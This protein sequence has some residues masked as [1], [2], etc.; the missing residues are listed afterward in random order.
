MAIA[1]LKSLSFYQRCAGGEFVQR[2]LSKHSMD[3][4]ARILLFISESSKGKTHRWATEVV[5]AGISRK[6]DYPPPNS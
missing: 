1:A 3:G 6:G 2:L 5:W 4:L